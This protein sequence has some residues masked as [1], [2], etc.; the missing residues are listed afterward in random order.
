MNCYPI[1]HKNFDGFYFDNL[2]VVKIA[3]SDLGI[4]QQQINYKIYYSADIESLIINMDLYTS[5]IPFQIWDMNGVCVLQS[6]LK[7][8]GNVIS[9]SHLSNGLYIV[10]WGNERVFKVLKN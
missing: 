8:S 2:T 4:S 1:C 6:E 3:G 10:K 7:Q 9:L 5:P